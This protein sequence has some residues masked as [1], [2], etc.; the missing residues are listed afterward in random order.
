[1]SK[2]SKLGYLQVGVEL[3]GGGIWH[4]WF[5]R[6]LGL[7]GRVVVAD[8]KGNFHTKLVKIDKPLLRIPTLAIHCEIYLLPLSFTIAY[9]CPCSIFIVDRGA[10]DNFKFNTESEFIPILALES[11]LNAKEQES[12]GSSK[13]PTSASSVQD[14]H[15]PALIALL[16]SELS[17]APESIHD[18]EV[19]VVPT[20]IA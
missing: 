17:V 20:L 14:N 8:A 5:D 7:A 12:K 13:P 11:Q 15:H 4:S 19:C 9:V 16:A 1:M 10:S 2:R 18:F 6:D 3:Y